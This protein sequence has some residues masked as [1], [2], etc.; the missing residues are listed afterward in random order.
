MIKPNFNRT[1][2]A[3]GIATGL[4]LGLGGLAAEPAAAADIVQR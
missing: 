3:A 1:F 4:L 2:V